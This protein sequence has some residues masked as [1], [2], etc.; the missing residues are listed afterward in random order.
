MVTYPINEEDEEYHSFSE[1]EL[2]NG[3]DE[4][5]TV[6]LEH[7]PIH[8]V[9]CMQGAFEESITDSTEDANAHQPDKTSSEIKRMKLLKED[10]YD[11]TT[12]SRW[13]HKAGAKFHTL[14][15]LMA[16][17][18]FGVHLLHQRLAKSDEEVVK[19]LQTHV[20]EV[21]GFLEKTTEDFDLALKDIDE[22]IRY[23][24]LPLEHLDIFDAMLDDKNFRTSIIDAVTEEL[25]R[26]LDKL[27]P[28]WTQGSEELAVI[29]TAMQGNAEGWYRCF[30][31]LQMKGNQLG[32]SLV[33]L[34]SIIAE[35]SKRAGTAS[36]RNRPRSRP[37]NQMQSGRTLGSS[38]INNSPPTSR[39]T[40]PIRA[41]K[42]LPRDPDLV[43]PAVQ[44]TLPRRVSTN[45]DRLYGQSRKQPQIPTSRGS[46]K[47]LE[48]R[49]ARDTRGADTSELAE[50]LRHSGPANTDHTEPRETR[51]PST[52]GRK[53]PIDTLNKRL[54]VHQI[55]EPQ[56]SPSHDSAY[57]SGSD[58][59]ASSPKTS[60]RPPT[61]LGLFPNTHPLTPSAA[62]TTSSSN[63][64][65]PILNGS[66]HDRKKS[67]SFSIKNIFQ[68]KHKVKG[69]SDL[70]GGHEKKNRY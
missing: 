68:N 7:P 12:T 54:S 66:V 11:E 21:D 53:S 57:S 2:E 6:T 13:K 39:F 26:Y 5:E 40:S 24:R 30:R 18:A 64:P 20:D 8:P 36:R 10:H 25:R 34:G 43:G 65:A 51:P 69:T 52:S 63:Q 15:K 61:P 37:M 3:Q 58:K 41:D 16:Q 1:G 48:P 46:A 35:I 44:A 31:S 28:C 50:F 67:S 55:K 45:P 56:I 60:A 4:L 59:R 70:A 32:V 29:S 22:R 9:A 47:I 14:W 49:E 23:L 62:S 33:Q 17:I 19:I 38:R 42:P 27:G